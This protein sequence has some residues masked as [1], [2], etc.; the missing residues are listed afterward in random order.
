VRGLIFQFANSEVNRGGYDGK[1]WVNCGGQTALTPAAN[2]KSSKLAQ[3]GDSYVLAYT[4][5]RTL[6]ATNPAVANSISVPDAG[7]FK[8]GMPLLLTSMDGQ[9]SQGL[10]AVGAIPDQ[11]T[12]V[13]TDALPT[14]PQLF[15]CSFTGRSNSAI[16]FNNLTL[17]KFSVDLLALVKYEVQPGAQK[18]LR[19][20]STAWPMGD[21]SSLTLVTEVLPSLISMN[22]N[23]T[24]TPTTATKGAYLANFSVQRWVPKIKLTGTEYVQSKITSAS[25]YNIAGVE[26]ANQ[27]AVPPPPSVDNL[28]VTCTLTTDTMLADFVDASTGKVIP[29]YRIDAFYS[30]SSVINKAAPSISS[31]IKVPPPPATPPP[32]D[33]NAR[34]WKATDIQCVAGGSMKLGGT[35]TINA[36]NFDL[37]ANAGNLPSCIDFTGALT[38]PAFCSVPADSTAST[39]LTYLSPASGDAQTVQCSDLA[40]AGLNITWSYDGLA[41]KCSKDGSIFIGRLVNAAMSPPQSGP[42]LGIKNGGCTWAGSGSTSCNAYSVLSANPSAQLLTVQ[43]TPEDLV[44]SGGSTAL[45]CN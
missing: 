15:G 42:V 7:S 32:T 25:G 35:P 19:L 31:G 33:Y 21:D 1:P 43:L 34:C 4:Q 30:E 36:V 8:V 23:E 9:K 24:F 27:G 20:V 14:P 28:F 38:V 5:R 6:G 16:L 40:L 26:I 18:Q 29:V 12:V 3:A 44:I 45:S 11:R 22:I 17:K 13:L 2:S 41:S 39:T 37:I 10:F